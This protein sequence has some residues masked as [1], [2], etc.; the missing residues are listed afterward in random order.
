MK[1]VKDWLKSYKGWIIALIISITL[2]CGFAWLVGVFSSPI[3]FRAKVIES[4]V[5]DKECTNGFGFVVE[6]EG[7]ERYLVKANSSQYSYYCDK[8][9][10]VLE[11]HPSPVCKEIGRIKIR[12]D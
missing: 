9:Y 7:G 6:E 1:K 3:I 11:E 10:I 5:S 2:I 8:E 4:V 12:I